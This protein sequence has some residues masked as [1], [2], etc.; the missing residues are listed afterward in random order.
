MTL[1]QDSEALSAYRQML[2][3]LGVDVD[4]LSDGVVIDALQRASE[5]WMKVEEDV[6]QMAAQVRDACRGARARLLDAAGS[7]LLRRNR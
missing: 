2:R 4:R 6:G 3:E 5:N 7:G 1:R